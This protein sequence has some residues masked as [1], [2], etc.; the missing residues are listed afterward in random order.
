LQILSL[1]LGAPPK[2]I[3][4]D[5]HNPSTA[6]LS[7]TLLERA[8]TIRTFGAGSQSTM[9]HATADRIPGGRLRARLRASGCAK[10]AR[11]L[12]SVLDP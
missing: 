4:I 1:T 8:D 9:T 7:A 12:A 11:T 10:Q 2:V 3:W 5:A 6:A